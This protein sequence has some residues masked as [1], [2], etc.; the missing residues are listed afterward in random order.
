M[1]SCIDD[2]IKEALKSQQNTLLRHH[3]NHKSF[4]IFADTFSLV[5]YHLFYFFDSFL[6]E[7]VASPGQNV[8]LA[9]TSSLAETQ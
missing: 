5:Q 9:G 6:I 1:D 7:A 3:K 8:G 4:A 2:R